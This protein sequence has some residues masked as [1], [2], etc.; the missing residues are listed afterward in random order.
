MNENNEFGYQ[1]NNDNNSNEQNTN[2]YY[3][4]QNEN[5]QPIYNI[6]TILLSINQRRKTADM[7]LLH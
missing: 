5:N 1:N 3:N 4:N 7:L 6:P 2:G